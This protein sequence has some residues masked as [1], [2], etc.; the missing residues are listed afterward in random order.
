MPLHI[1]MPVVTSV[2]ALLP[3]LSFAAWHYRRNELAMATLFAG[4]PVLLPVEWGMMTMTTRGFVTGL[5]FMAPLPWLLALRRSWLRSLLIG[6][7]LYTSL[8]AN[9]NALLVAAPFALWYALRPGTTWMDRLAGIAGALPPL[10]LQV[11][12][13]RF[14]AREPERIVHRL[15]DWRLT[16]HP[17]ELIPEAL[18]QLDRHFA[19][20]APLSW[21]YGHLVLIMLLAVSLWLWTTGQRY[22]ALSV[23]SVF[24]VILLS[25][26]FPKVHDGFDSVFLPFSRMYLALPLLLVWALS[27]GKWKVTMARTLAFALLLAVPLCVAL[28]LNH[29]PHVLTAALDGQ[30]AIPVRELSMTAFRQQL[31]KI[32]STASQ[33]KV[34]LII[35]LDSGDKFRSQLIAYGGPVVA[36]SLPPTLYV[37]IDRR[38]WRRQEERA[39]RRSTILFVGGETE[40]WDMLMGTEPGLIRIGDAEDRLHLLTGE[41]LAI[42]S[43]LA[44]LGRTLD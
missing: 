34:D 23:A 20:L 10:L 13:L 12:A 35:A 9:Q 3:F 11:L 31:E 6:A 15:D 21:P 4:M 18:Q 19:W 40:R 1:A 8:I 26:A 38:Y 32:D 28:K 43:V 25:F 42:D 22:P 24:P 5:A 36:P 33:H 17:G 39:A 7:V 29:T 27:L 41:P 30:Q 2:L 14:Y 44:L 37:G 16:F